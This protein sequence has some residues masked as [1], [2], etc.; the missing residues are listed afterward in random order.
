MRKQEKSR[1]NS[2]ASLV[3]VLLF[4]NSQLENKG[5]NLILFCYL[6]VKSVMDF[7]AIL[8]G[9][10]LSIKTEITQNVQNA[11]KLYKLNNNKKKKI[12][13]FNKI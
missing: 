6:N 10:I 11:K 13:I 9:L 8:V 4:L 5:S 12:L 7:P 1:N 2:F 3:T